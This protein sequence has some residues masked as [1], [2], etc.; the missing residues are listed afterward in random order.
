MTRTKEVGPERVLRGPIVQE[1]MRIET[2]RSSGPDTWVQ[3]L[4]GLTFE[5]FQSGDPDFQSYRN[6]ARLEWHEV[7]NVHDYRLD[8]DAAK[9]PGNV[10]DRGPGHGDP[11][12]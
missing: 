1:P 5:R 9:N 6:S 7:T 8:V 11:S 4:V 3:G 10:H 12:G 2:A